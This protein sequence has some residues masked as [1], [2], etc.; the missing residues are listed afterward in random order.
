MCFIKYLI[1]EWRKLKNLHIIFL[2]I[3]GMASLLDTKESNAGK[4]QFGWPAL[5]GFKP[6][7][8]PSV[9]LKSQPLHHGGWVK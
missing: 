8:F 6:T 1:N 5:V 7:P 9:Y 2:G 4:P 3:W